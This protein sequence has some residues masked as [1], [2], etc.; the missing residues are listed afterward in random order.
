LSGDLDAQR[1]GW[2]R[3]MDDLK[4]PREIDHSIPGDT[5]NQPISFGCKVERV[6]FQVHMPNPWRQPPTGFH[7]IFCHRQRISRIQRDAIRGT[8]ARHVV[9]LQQVIGRGVLMV[10]HRDPDAQLFGDR[11]Y[12]SQSIRRRA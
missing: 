7:G 2:A 9:Q 4:Y 3:R 11:Q 12:F 1:H 8:A 5:P 6:V 10:F